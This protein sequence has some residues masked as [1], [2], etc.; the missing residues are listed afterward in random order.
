MKKYIILFLPTGVFV[1]LFIIFLTRYYTT[2]RDEADIYS[3]TIYQTPPIDWDDATLEQLSKFNG[4]IQNELPN[5]DI[6]FVPTSSYT[7][8]YIIIKRPFKEIPISD[9][10]KLLPLLDDFIH[11]LYNSR[12]NKNLE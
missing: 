7:Y 10:N 11:S 5:L 3:Y 12:K 9:E 2:H 1:I 8:E 6:Y 4:K